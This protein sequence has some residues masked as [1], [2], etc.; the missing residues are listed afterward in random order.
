MMMAAILDSMELNVIVTNQYDYTG[1]VAGEYMLLVLPVPP[2][3]ASMSCAHALLPLLLLSMLPFAALADEA[4]RYPAARG[5]QGAQ[6]PDTRRDA[7]RLEEKSR[8]KQLWQ[9]LSHEERDALRQQ[10]RAN[11]ERMSPEERQRLHQAYRKH[12]KLQEN[13]QKREEGG[14]DDAH[15]QEELAQQRDARKK[16]HEAYWQSL[17]PE[18]RETLRNALRETIRHWRHEE[19]AKIMTQAPPEAFPP[20]NAD[21]KPAPPETLP[22]NA[23][24]V[25]RHSPAQ[26]E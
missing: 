21:T 20:D 3:P 14:G 10:M 2:D 7:K 5:E 13:R 19:A 23:G 8:L 15:W 6:P 9:Q 11:W 1:A 26:R 22:G 17:T 4:A 12:Q 18:E 25:N 16:A 24:Q